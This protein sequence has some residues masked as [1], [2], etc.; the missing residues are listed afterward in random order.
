MPSKLERIRHLS[1]EKNI[2]ESEV[3]I[4]MR[5]VKSAR[6]YYSRSYDDAQSNDVFNFRSFHVL[7]VTLRKVSSS[8]GH[9]KSL[10]YL[11]LSHGSFKTLPESICKLW[12]LQILKLDDCFRFRKL[13]NNLIRLKALRHLSLNDCKRLSSLPPNIG[14]M[15]SLRTLSMYVV[16]KGGGFLLAEL[17]QLNF[18]IDRFHIKHLERVKSV[19]DAKEANMLSK[20]VN[21]LQL[22]W[23]EESPP[24]ENVEQILEVLQPYPQQLQELCVYGYTG[25]HFPEWMSSPSLKH[26]RKLRL[27]HCKSCLLFQH[28]GKLPSLEVLELWY[29]PNLTRLSR[30]DGENMFPQLF[31]LEIRR[32]PNLLGLPCLPSLKAL[33]IF[34]EC[35]HDLLSSIHKLGSLE[36]IDFAFIKELKCFPEGILTNPTSLKKLEIEHCS[37]LEIVDS[38]KLPSLEKLEIRGSS[39]IEGLGEDLQHLTSLQSLMLGELPNLTSLPDSLGNLNSLQNLTI[40]SC[41]KLICLPASIQ[42]LSALKILWIY[43]CHEL[44]K[45][46][47]RETGEDWPKISHIQNLKGMF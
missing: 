46:C 16:G 19:E 10:R 41:Q 38:G 25:S 2:S 37:E 26:L 12:N 5:N 45:R 27:V 20:K 22:S 6:T 8:I 21:S 40:W 24:Q 4:W 23:D 43:D 9:L 17:G 7:K 11:D 32:C 44:E 15:I 36:S 29:L 28:L 34:F 30:E 39:K 1:F 47:K 18:K 14:K 13:P 42:S 3:S 31:N 35:S 33:R